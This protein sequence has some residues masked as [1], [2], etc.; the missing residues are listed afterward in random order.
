M[1]RGKETTL[2]GGA[3]RGANHPLLFETEE[4]ALQWA[5]NDTNSQ[6]LWALVVVPRAGGAAPLVLPEGSGSPGDP[7]RTPFPGWQWR[8]VVALPTAWCLVQGEGSVFVFLQLWQ[9]LWGF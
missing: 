7:Q 4:D 3:G 1:T 2:G 5:H 8:V 6:D 9:N